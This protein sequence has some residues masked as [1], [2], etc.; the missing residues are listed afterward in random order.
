MARP[1]PGDMAPD[2]TLPTDGGGS[3]T[4]SALKKPAVVYFYPKDDTPGCTREAQ[5]FTRLKPEFDAAGVEIIGISPQS[6]DSHDKFIAKCDLGITLGADTD[7]TVVEAYGVWVDK[8]NYGRTYQG[9]E[10]ATFLVGADRKVARVWG[11]VKVD[12]HAEKVLEAA[13]ALGG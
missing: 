8:Q 10:R 3:V 12:G 5:A 9:V 1:G 4:L 11:N 6:A 13:K 7:K 2:F